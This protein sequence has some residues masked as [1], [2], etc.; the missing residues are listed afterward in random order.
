MEEMNCS[1][2]GGRDF[3]VTRTKIICRQCGKSIKKPDE[4][5]EKYE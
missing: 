3:Q 2:C 1:V 5:G 4:E